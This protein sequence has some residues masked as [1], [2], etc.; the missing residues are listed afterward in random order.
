M[1]EYS[2][3][4]ILSLSLSVHFSIVDSTRRF[5][6]TKIPFDIISV[7]KFDIISVESRMSIVIHPNV[8]FYHRCKSII[9]INPPSKIFR[10]VFSTESFESVFLPKIQPRGDPKEDSLRNERERERERQAIIRSDNTKFKHARRRACIHRG[11]GV[12]EQNP[13]RGPFNRE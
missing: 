11:R 7:E 8:K 4:E 5:S 6:F 13:C 12:E 1:Q 3:L 9:S 2:K 10:S